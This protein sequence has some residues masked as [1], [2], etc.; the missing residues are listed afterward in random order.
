MDADFV[1]AALLPVFMTSA[2]ETA[3]GAPAPA[4]PAGATDVFPSLPVGAV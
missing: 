4:L 2:P 3:F 1:F